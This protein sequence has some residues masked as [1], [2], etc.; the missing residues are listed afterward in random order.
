[1][2]MPD[3]VAAAFNRQVTMEL[4]SAAAYLQM[5]AF[6]AERNLSGMAAW[7]RAQSHEERSHALRFLGFVLDRGGRALIG[8]MPAPAAEFADAEAV[9]AAALEQEQ[10]VTAAIHD[11]YRMAVDAGDLA[12]LPFLQSFIAEQT[13]EEAM[14]DEILERIRLADGM[15]AA[16]LLLDGELGARASG[17]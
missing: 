15:P 1:M 14:V 7:M 9:F 2:R 6:F 5:S 8:D 16:L 13:E 12:S 17:S 3:E 11:L 10:E 4:A